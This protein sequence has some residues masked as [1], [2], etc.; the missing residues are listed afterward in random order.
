MLYTYSRAEDR[1]PHPRRSYLDSDVV[2]GGT[3]RVQT[4]ANGKCSV[5][6][7]T[8]TL[9]MPYPLKGRRVLVTAGSRGLGALVA[10][11]LGAE[12]CDVAINY[13]SNQD[14]AK[15]VAE[16]IVKSGTRAII[17]KGDAGNAKDIEALVA[18][19]VKMF[20]GLDIVISNAG[21]TK[22][23]AFGDLHGNTDE[24]WDKCWT[25]NV[26]AQMQL[27]RAAAPHFNANPDGGAFLMTSSTAGV[28]PAGSSMPYS[29]TKAAGLHLMKCLALTQ[30]PKI[31]VNAVLPGLMLT[32]W[33]HFPSSP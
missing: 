15:Q 16:D 13:V 21:F 14:S 1:S 2:V 17:L 19:T 12:G 3:P 30:G 6:C 11:K 24:E 33:V 4:D 27:L 23:S 10:K 5:A 28:K 22:L 32:D 9:K 29:V 26:K 25:V 18:E 31:R 7:I 20:G 8:K